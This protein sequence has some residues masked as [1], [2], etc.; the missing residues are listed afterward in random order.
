MAKAPQ[1][2]KTSRLKFT[3]FLPDSDGDQEGFDFFD[4]LDLPSI[5]PQPDD[6]KY[7]VLTTDRID[8]IAT[9]FYGDPVLWWVVAL[10]NDF[11]ILPDDLQEGD[12][13]IIPSPRFVNSDL[14]KIQ[15]RRS[16]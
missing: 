13:I 3:M 7:T 15:I 16:A 1:I 9:K 12:E 14:F 10:A 5:P 8:S 11:E 4:L 6:L 2:R